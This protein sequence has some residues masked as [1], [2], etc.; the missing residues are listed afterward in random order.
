MGRVTCHAKQ[1]P[2]SHKFIC[3][4]LWLRDEE[5]NCPVSLTLSLCHFR[6]A[7]ISFF[8][9]HYKFT[10]KLISHSTQT[11]CETTKSHAEK[12]NP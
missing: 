7:E 11:L 8:D 1:W 3:I 9:L 6:V 10:T 4:G 5:Q 2:T 12:M